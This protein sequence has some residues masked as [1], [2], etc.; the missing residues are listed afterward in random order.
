MTVKD[1]N[2]RLRRGNSHF[3]Q[4]GSYIREDGQPVK[5][6]AEGPRQQTPVITL[7]GLNYLPYMKQVILNLGLV[8]K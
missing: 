1:Y 2:E 4:I 6:F 5:V 8:E 7:R 3:P